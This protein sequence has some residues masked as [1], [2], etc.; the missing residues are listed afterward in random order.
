VDDRVFLKKEVFQDGKKIGKQI[1]KIN[2]NKEPALNIF[3]E[4]TILCKGDST[5]AKIVGNEQALNYKWSP[6]LYI[7]NNVGNAVVVKPLKSDYIVVSAT[8]KNG[9][10]S[11]D[12]VFVEVTQ[13]EFQFDIEKHPIIYEG[14]KGPMNI[15]Y[16]ITN[17]H[18]PFSIS[19]DYDS[20][21][22]TII[23]K[24]NGIQ[25]GNGKNGITDQVF[26]FT[27]SD[28][29]GCSI[30]DFIFLEVKEKDKTE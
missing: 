8:D 15:T 27:V 3:M 26:D 23:E 2:L 4:D 22:N 18:P 16:S 20:N 14:D 6:S 9:C 1:V 7:F 30:R 17:G 19:W 10:S 13:P 25:V 12:S 5:I 28:N 24:D 11:S 21:I 29:K